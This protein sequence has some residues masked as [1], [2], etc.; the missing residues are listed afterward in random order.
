VT[1]CPKCGGPVYEISPKGTAR[2]V[3]PGSGD[4]AVKGVCGKCY[5]YVPEGLDQ[6]PK[7]GGPVWEIVDMGTAARAAASDAADPGSVRDMAARM[8]EEIRSDLARD[9]GD[10]LKDVRA[11]ARPKPPPG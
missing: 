7:C 8:R 1:T 3:G 9:L 4:V 2:G 11:R 6:C 5:D 10:A